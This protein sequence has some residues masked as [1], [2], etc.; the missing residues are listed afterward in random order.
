MINKTNIN[1]I[2]KKI[3][4]EEVNLSVEKVELNKIDDIQDEIQKGYGNIES[5][6]EA[7]DDARAAVIKANDIVRFELNE[8]LDNAEY[9]LKELMQSLKELGL[10]S[11]PKTKEIQSEIE[12]LRKAINDAESKNDRLQY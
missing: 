7:F 10:S 5:F 11:S 6:E 4:T 8:P 2:L 12:S 3:H 9:M 1:K